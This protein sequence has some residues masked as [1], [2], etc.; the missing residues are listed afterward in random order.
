MDDGSV[1]VYTI[2]G[3][4]DRDEA[5]NIISN[6]TR[7]A[8]SLEGKRAGERAVIPSAAGTEET[9]IECIEPL[10]DTIRQWIT[11]IPTEL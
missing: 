3:E 6:M 5:L 1:R 10:S 4:W 2:L 7:L 9:T 11:T 8:L